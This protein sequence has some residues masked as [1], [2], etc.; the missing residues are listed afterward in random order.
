MPPKGPKSRTVS[1]PKNQSSN[2][3]HT[4]RVDR[5]QRTN[6]TIQPSP[7]SNAA[8]HER[9]PHGHKARPVAS[10]H[11]PRYGSPDSQSRQRG[12]R[13]KRDARARD[14]PVTPTATRTPFPG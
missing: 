14:V 2:R 8:S 10:Q 12:Y 5:S 4:S 1:F 11:P 9:S 13:E 3:P 7:K 6:P